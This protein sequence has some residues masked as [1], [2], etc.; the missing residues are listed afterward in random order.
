[1]IT[2][3][4]SSIRIQAPEPSFNGGSALTKY[5]FVRDDGPLTSFMSQI[6]SDTNTHTFE[7]LVSGTI[8]RFK[9]SAINSIGQ[10]EWSNI[11]SFYAATNPS[12]PQNFK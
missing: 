2:S 11:V 6:E 8:Y 7:G 10:G 5:V 4:T 3:T 9:V 1:M 12:D